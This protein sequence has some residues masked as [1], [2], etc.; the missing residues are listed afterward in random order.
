M[1]AIPRPRIQGHFFY[2]DRPNPELTHR[3]STGTRY[4]PL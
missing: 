3:G 4:I 1:I 2:E